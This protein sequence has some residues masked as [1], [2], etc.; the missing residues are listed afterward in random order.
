ME[1]EEEALEAEGVGTEGF[2]RPLLHYFA[3]PFILFISL[4]NLFVPRGTREEAPL[5]RLLMGCMC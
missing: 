3:F 5:W 2:V 1:R 4:P